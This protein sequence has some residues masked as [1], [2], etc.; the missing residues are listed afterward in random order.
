MDHRQISKKYQAK[1]VILSQVISK[2]TSID[3]YRML[4]LDWLKDKAE[5][6]YRAL[7]IYDQQELKTTLDTLRHKSEEQLTTLNSIEVE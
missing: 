6:Q 3:R 4:V 5:N 7:T 2:S 1:C